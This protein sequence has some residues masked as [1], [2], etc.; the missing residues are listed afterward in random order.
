M[1]PAD[2]I[3]DVREALQEALPVLKNA[4]LRE[5]V[6]DYLV[7]GRAQQIPHLDS[8]SMA[9]TYV[10]SALLMLQLKYTSEIDFYTS[11]IRVHIRPFPLLT[12]RY[13]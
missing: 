5:A 1:I 7:T 11:G 2:K 10:N 3:A 8:R 4:R 13:K 9:E 12:S 6:V